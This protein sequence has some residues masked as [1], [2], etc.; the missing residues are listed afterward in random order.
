[1]IHEQFF[2]GVTG[3]QLRPVAGLLSS[4]D[5]LAGL[6]FRN[7]KKNIYFCIQKLSLSQTL[8]FSSSFIL[9]NQCRR[10]QGFNARKVISE[11]YDLLYCSVLSLGGNVNI[12]RMSKPDMGSIFHI[13]NQWNILVIGNNYVIYQNYQNSMLVTPSD[14]K[15]TLCIYS[16]LQIPHREN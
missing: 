1:M 16:C 6:A 2:K 10:T 9:A 12:R 3:F 13:N 4:R 15:R 7:L 5:F 8:W 11:V 14:T